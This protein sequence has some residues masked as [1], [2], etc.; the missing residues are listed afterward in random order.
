[1]QY[2]ASVENAFLVYNGLEY[3]KYAKVPPPPQK[4]KSIVYGKK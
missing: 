3:K 2:D 4:K 1:M